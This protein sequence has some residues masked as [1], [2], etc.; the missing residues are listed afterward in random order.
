MASYNAV[1]GGGAG[2]GPTVGLTSSNILPLQDGTASGKYRRAYA[3]ITSARSNTG[4]IFL[5]LH[6][7]D[8]A[9]LNTG[10]VL[11][12]G[13]AYEI[14]RGNLY[15]GPVQAISD[16]AAQQLFIQLGN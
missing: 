3:L 14:S 6:E 16:V 5:R 8:D 9:V 11:Y 15:Q 1:H 12:P 10:I 4:N 13:D 7:S 2:S